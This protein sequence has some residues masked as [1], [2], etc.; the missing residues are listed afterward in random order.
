MEKKVFARTKGLTDKPFHYCPGCTHGIIHRLIAETLCE[1]G[2]LETTIGVSSVGCTYN[3]YEYFSCDM[4]QAAHGRAPAV[5]TGIKRVHPDRTIFTYQGDGDLAAI[6]TAEIVHA[7]ARGEKI[8]TFFVNNAI[9]GMTSGQMAPTTLLGQVT[10]TTP[11]GRKAELQGFPINVSEMLAT[12]RGKLDFETFWFGVESKS[13]FYAENIA[14]MGL[15][16]IKC[17]IV[18]K[19]EKID[20]T[21]PTPGG[22]MVLNALSAAAVAKALGLSM[23]QIKRGIENFEP[24]AMRMAV[25]KTDFGLTLIND[26]YNANPVSMKAAIDVLCTS[27]GRTVAIMGDM[28]ELGDFAPSLHYEVG[29]YAAKS[30]VSLSICIG[31]NGTRI[32]GGVKENGGNAIYFE[33]Q[34]EFLQS[35]LKDLFTSGDT[36]LIKASRGMHFEKTAEKLQEVK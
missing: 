4:V 5:A 2:I 28:F 3:N 33:T 31:E 9:Y 35:N 30:G 22:H 24:T 23:G 19:D 36:V 12:L 10:T 1:M 15:D 29:E 17:T 27:K 13:D 25:I 6:G 8:C 16:G 26:A 14:P 7:A 20:V 18:C 11:F 32:Y 34:E 21:I